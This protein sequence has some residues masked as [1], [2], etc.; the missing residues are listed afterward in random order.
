MYLKRKIY[1]KL[2]TNLKNNK[3]IILTGARQVGKTSL[4]KKLLEKVDNGKNTAFIDMDL[5]S[6][7]EKAENLDKFLDFLILNGYNKKLSRFYVFVDELQKAKDIAGIFKNIYDHYPNIKIIAS[8]SSSL[9]IKNKIKESLAGRKFIFEIYPLDFEEF[10]IFKQDKKAREYFKNIPKLK[11]SEIELPYKLNQYLEEFLIFGGYPEVALSDDIEIKKRL[12][13][14]IFDLYIEK[15]IMIFSDIENIPAFKKIIEILAVNN[16]QM[17][18]Y[19]RLAQEA[20]IHNKT[21][22]SYLSLIEN[23]YITKTIR[24]FYSN[25]NKEII[26][27]PKIYFLDIGVRNYFLNNYSEIKKRIDK[28]Q[29][30]ETYILQEL[31]KNNFDKI[32]FWRTKNNQEIDFILEANK[33]IPLEIKYKSQGEIKHLKTIFYFLKEH[34]L[35]K[36]Y[37]LSK[38]YNKEI[39]KDKRNVL[40]RVGVNFVDGLK[41]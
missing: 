29:I 3:I 36:A 26:K 22:R 40:C 16:G 39:N 31:I 38:N 8:G 2:L 28:G 19:N 12:L 23:T 10:L 7:T 37:L 17:I 32:K 13:A 25:K 35:K 11:N 27:T 41:K 15:D 9:S 24:P 33:T 21:V 20:G 4:M 34:N 14:S 30:W 6:N 18:N 5:T 1:S